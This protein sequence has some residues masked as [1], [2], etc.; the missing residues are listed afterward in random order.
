MDTMTPLE[1]I[2]KRCLDC[3]GDFAPEARNCGITSCQLHP[4]R[5]G[6]GSGTGKPS[7]KTIKAYCL[8]CSG[9]SETNMRHCPSRSCALWPYRQ[10]HNPNRQ[11]ELSEE[12]RIRRAELL[13]KSLGRDH[14]SSPNFNEE[15]LARVGV[16]GTLPGSEIQRETPM[17]QEA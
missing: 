16:G 6:T 1:A 11:Y 2:R 14:V 10:G 3:S 9:D 8:W 5:M 4:Y 7:V 12:E 15:G 17:E 13:N